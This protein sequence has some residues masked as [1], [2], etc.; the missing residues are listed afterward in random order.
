LLVIAVL[1]CVNGS[2]GTE[3]AGSMGWNSRQQARI[4]IPTPVLTGSGST[5]IISACATPQA[6]RQDEL[7]AYHQQLG[8]GYNP[9]CGPPSNAF[10]CVVETGDSNEPLRAKERE[11][12]F[13]PSAAP[14]IA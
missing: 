1:R 8:C 3:T 7:K 14:S 13:V 2:Q 11:K 6:P 4:S 5:G 9:L 12:H 10:P